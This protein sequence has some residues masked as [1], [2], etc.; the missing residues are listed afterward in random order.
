MLREVGS[1]ALMRAVHQF[2]LGRG[3]EEPRA[4]AAEAT[5]A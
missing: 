5:A 2:R 1:A 4:G 3:G